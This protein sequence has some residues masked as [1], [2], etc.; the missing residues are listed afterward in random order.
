VQYFTALS[1]SERIVGRRFGLFKLLAATEIFA[2]KFLSVSIGAGIG[3][4]DL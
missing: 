3:S 2:T 4:P 1:C